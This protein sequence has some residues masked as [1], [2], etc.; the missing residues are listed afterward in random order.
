MTVIEVIVLTET[1]ARLYLT[2]A[3]IVRLRFTA[4]VFL[5]TYSSD[6]HYSRSCSYITMT[7]QNTH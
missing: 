7:R 3:Y 5:M 1:A 4:R 6:L 2:K